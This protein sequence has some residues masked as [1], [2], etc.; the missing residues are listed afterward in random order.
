MPK[1]HDYIAVDL[2]AE[3]G[4]V[5]L[6]TISDS[7]LTMKEVH[8]FL[9]TPLEIEG[10]RRWD[11]DKLFAEIKAGI[12]K[13]LKECGGQAEGI[14]VDS[15]GVDFGL[16]DSDGNLVE[17]PYCYRDKRNQPAYEQ[18]LKIMP[19]KDIYANSG[20]QLMAI[21]TLYQLI[22]MKSSEALKKAKKMLFTADLYAYSLCG[23]AFC[24]YTLASTSQIMDMK[25][26]KWSSKIFD[27][28]G[29]DTGLMP[30]LVKAGTKVG[31]LKD[32]ICKEMGCNAVDLIAV[33]S[34][35][36]ACAVAAIPKS[37][38]NW[39]YLSS[40]TW[41][42]IGV[43]TKQAIINDKSY[44]HGFTNEGGFGDTIRFLKNIVGL[45]MLQECRRHWQKEGQDFT[46]EQLTNMAQK[47]EPF[48]ASLDLNRDEFVLSGD[49]PNK[50]NSYL[51]QSG[52]KEISDK[53]QMARIILES[54]AFEYGNKLNAIE[55]IT[56]KKIDVLHIVGG[57][58]KNELLSQFAANATGRK[59]IT[60]PVEATAIGNILIQAIAKGHVESIEKA[61]EIVRT[62]FE[63]KE[64]YPQ[65]TDVWQKIK[66][67]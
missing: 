62:S 44:Q 56:G 39:A 8:R 61:R 64:Y 43:E 13:A 42:L 23:R 51:K 55:E 45:W 5:I 37:S 17:M 33:G 48:K 24:E 58:S 10:S 47:A 12:A 41:S 54:L 1:R 63:V 4:R 66:K 14:G 26:G 2:G 59:V 25:A 29:L 21:N 57:G 19:A 34:H 53:G 52:Q 32:S 18:A 20:I 65:D 15:W 27:A 40:G 46:Y 36:T 6:G 7:K 3:S 49:M 30:D 9:N 60:G 28:F 22:A 16:I 38:E 67:Q 11:Y 35:D 31:K 50:I